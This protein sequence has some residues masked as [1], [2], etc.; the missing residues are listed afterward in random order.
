VQAMRVMRTVAAVVAAAALVGA[1]GGGSGSDEERGAG[2]GDTADEP[3]GGGSAT[4]ATGATDPTCD[5]L[6]LDQVSELFGRDA[7]VVPSD[8]SAAVVGNCM[9]QAE[10][11]TEGSPTLYQL[12]LSVYEG[13]A[14]F[15]PTMWGGDPETLDGPGDEAFLVRSGG[16]LGTT[17][18]YRD[19][20]RS[21]FLS[22]GILLDPDAPDPGEQADDV[23][24]LLTA[25]HAALG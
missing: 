6:Q 12:Q 8:A 7:H 13:G 16:T 4:T 1:C 14:F 22:Y 19:A 24:A 2:V 3:D 9:W 18:G 15:D 25:V 17:A 20:T 21:V 11:G 23:V 10:A 5:L